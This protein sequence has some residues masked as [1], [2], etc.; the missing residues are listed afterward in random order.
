MIKIVKSL[1]ASNFIT[2]EGMHN[3]DAR[4]PIFVKKDN[5]MIGMVVAERDGWI[6]KT[7]GEFGAYGHFNS[8]NQ[9]IEHGTIHYRY[10]FF[11]E[12]L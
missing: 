2:M 6:V 7:G 5:K 4:V 3:I 12:D 10:E 1:P 11:M 8:R 9:C